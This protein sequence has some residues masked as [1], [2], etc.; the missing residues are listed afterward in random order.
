VSPLLSALLC[1]VAVAV[2]T[3]ASSAVRS[4]SRIWLRHWVERRLTGA[5]LAELYLER[6]QRLVVSAG[7]GVTLSVFLTGVVVATIAGAA[8]SRVRLTLWL[9]VAALAIV[10]LGQAIPRAV[11]RRW[12][13]RVVPVLIPVLRVVDLIVAPVRWLGMA[14]GR[15]FVARPIVPPADE[16]R[17]NIEELLREGALEGVGESQE[18]AIIAGVVQFGE[19]AARDV[20]TPRE[21]VFALPVDTPPRELARQIAL[22]GFSRVPLYRQTLDDVLGIAYVFDV[23]KTAGE[24]APPVRP[25]AAAHAATP[26]NELLF[27]MLRSGRHLAVVRDD[28]AGSRMLGI[29]TLED[30]LEELVG[31]IRDEHDEPAPPAQEPRRPAT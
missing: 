13:A 28:G 7:V 17:D 9:V 19:K 23:Y 10:V 8:G 30:L 29:V 12:P 22:S 24:T 2:L 5:S 14:A 1:V 25:I 27:A 6:P 20:M 4:V 16:A 21:E 3:A 26:C 31:D 11:G 15:P 18:I